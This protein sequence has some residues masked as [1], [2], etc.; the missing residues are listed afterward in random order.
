MCAL[1][2]HRR[3]SE[4]SRAKHS[5]CDSAGELPKLWLA[6]VSL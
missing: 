4:Q 2:L 5:S 6:T 3:A 1:V